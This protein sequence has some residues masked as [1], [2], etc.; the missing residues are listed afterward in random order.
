MGKPHRF[1]RWVGRAEDYVDYKS[2]SRDV[3]YMYI[4]IVL[5]NISCMPCNIVCVGLFSPVSSRGRV[6][7]KGWDCLHT[8]SE[9][10]CSEHCKESVPRERGPAGTGGEASPPSLTINAVCFDTTCSIKP[11]VFSVLSH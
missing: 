5:R 1:L 6:H 10:G 11:H 2:N 7:S 9:G 8:A 3:R 4:V